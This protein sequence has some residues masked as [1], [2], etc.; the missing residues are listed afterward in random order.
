MDKIET[1]VWL[2]DDFFEMSVEAAANLLK[3]GRETG[4]RLPLDGR[5]ISLLIKPEK[6]MPSIQVHVKLMDATGRFYTHRLGWLGASDYLGNLKQADWMI[7]SS[8]LKPLAKKHAPYSLISIGFSSGRQSEGMQKNSVFLKSISSTVVKNFE[9][10][11]HE[12]DTVVVQDF[13]NEHKWIEMTGSVPPEVITISEDQIDKV[14]YFSWLPAGIYETRGIRIVDKAGLVPALV[15][16]DMKDKYFYEAG[17]TFQANVEGSIVGFRVVGFLNYFPTVNTD[18][19]DLVLVDLDTLRF[20]LNLDPIANAGDVDEIWIDIDETKMPKNISANYLKNKP[21]KSQYLYDQ[22]QMIARFTQ[23]PLT[24]A[25]WMMLFT[26]SLIALSLLTTL[27]FWTR[28]V[29]ICKLRLNQSGALENLGM[30]RRSI[31]LIQWVESTLVLILGSLIGLWL[32]GF[33]GQLIMPILGQSEDGNGV[34]PPYLFVYSWSPVLIFITTLSV[35][36]SS[37]LIVAHRFYAKY[38]PA[39]TLRSSTEIQH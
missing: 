27:Y 18:Y 1:L 5:T 31:N 29:N 39:E 3:D 37:S 19:D 20:N 2:R 4:L 21:F 36:C 33:I 12:V 11:R 23:D 9:D 8:P 10:G 26:V 17:D 32:G 24:S 6:P 15:N 25:G 35:L 30:T 16:Q 28:T 38:S 34:V 14:L 13:L 22:S 7:L